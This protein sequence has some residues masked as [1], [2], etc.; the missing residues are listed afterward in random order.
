[1]YV[2]VRTNALVGIERGR[3]PSFPHGREHGRCR[4]KENGY[5]DRRRDGERSP[6]AK[7]AVSFRRDL[8]LS[9][10]LSVS[11]S[12][13]LRVNSLIY[14]CAA[15]GVTY[16]PGKPHS[17]NDSRHFA[18]PLAPDDT[19][20]PNG[21][22]KYDTDFRS[23]ETNTGNSRQIAQERTH[24][25]AVSAGPRRGIRPP[26]SHPPRIPPSPVRSHIRMLE[27]RRLVAITAESGLVDSARFSS[28]REK[29]SKSR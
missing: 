19:R 18:V 17:P 4:R 25:P 22:R 29:R 24:T 11:P 15:R 10:S 27:T 2:R 28:F 9:L 13:P 7:F 21:K 6:A 26:D 1:M 12:V 5:T 14:V 8:S 3:N 16:P 20:K 23:V